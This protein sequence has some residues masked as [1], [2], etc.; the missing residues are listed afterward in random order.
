[1]L[2]EETLSSESRNKGFSMQIG[3]LGNFW[4]DQCFPSHMQGALVLFVYLVGS[5]VV[6]CFPL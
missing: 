4:E 2:E 5:V 1:M 6:L 3:H